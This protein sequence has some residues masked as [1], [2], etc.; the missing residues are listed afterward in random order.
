MVS[1]RPNLMLAPGSGLRV[2]VTRESERAWVSLSL[3][4]QELRIVSQYLDMRYSLEYIQKRIFS[5]QHIAGELGLIGCHSNLSCDKGQEFCLLT[6]RCG[7]R[8]SRG[9]YPD[10]PHCRCLSE[11]A[12]STLNIPPAMVW[13]PQAL[14]ECLFF[15]WS[16]TACQLNW[17]FQSNPWG[18][19]SC[20][21]PGLPWPDPSCW[22][23]PPG[24]S[25]QGDVEVIW[26]GKFIFKS[27]LWH[28]RVVIIYLSR[29]ELIVV[30]S[31]DQASLWKQTTTEVAGR[32]RPYLGSKQRHF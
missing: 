4:I 15:S 22:R 25:R 13:R 2:K 27:K 24:W 1:G 7:P 5:R 17:R 9:Q 26:K 23:H 16:G 19:A 20:R 10:C 21:C 28:H 18:T 30:S 32:S 6:W 12:L 11:N 14:C 8:G 3:T 29:M 31:T